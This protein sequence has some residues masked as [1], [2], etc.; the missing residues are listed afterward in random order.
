MKR[1]KRFK[2]GRVVRVFASFRLFG[3]T[4]PT[5]AIEGGDGDVSVAVFEKECS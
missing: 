5:I 4:I 2:D 1:A 3:S